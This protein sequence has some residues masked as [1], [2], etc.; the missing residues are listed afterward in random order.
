[1]DELKQICDEFTIFRDG[2]FIKT[3][4]IYD[5]NQSDIVA[6]MVG[7]ALKDQFPYVKAVPGEEILKLENCTKHGVVENIS[8]SVR[9]GEA[10]GF[11][12]LVGSGRTELAR[13]IFGVDKFDQGTVLINQRPVEINTVKKQLT[14]EFTIQQKTE[15]KMD[16]FQMQRLTSI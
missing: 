6:L 14:M 2:E 15:R 16:Y 10:V 13:C 5:Y 1:M 8:F 7:R 3:G 11:A 9:K 12:G 4:S